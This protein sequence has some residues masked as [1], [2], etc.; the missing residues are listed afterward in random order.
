MIYALSYINLKNSF[1][2]NI[3]YYSENN[4]INKII[5][6]QPGKCQRVT[7]PQISSSKRNIFIL[8]IFTES[9]F[10]INITTKY[11]TCNYEENTLCAFGGLVVYDNHNKSYTKISSVCESHQGFYKHRNIYSNSSVINIVMYSFKEY[12]S[13]HFRLQI[14]TTQYKLTTK[15]TYLHAFNNGCG[16]RRNQKRC[17]KLWAQTRNVD[18][19][20]I[21]WPRQFIFVN[22]EE[23]VITHLSQDI[24]LYM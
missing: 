18:M 9:K 16:D 10:L 7:Y 3:R 19:D 21:P 6:I 1:H 11:F 24:T 14:S 5:F 17:A 15:S 12:G 4:L 2:N 8:Q 23:C 20:F 22:N 13:L